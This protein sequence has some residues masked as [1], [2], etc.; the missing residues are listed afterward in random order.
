MIPDSWEDDLRRRRHSIRN[1]NGSTH[2]EAIQKSSSNEI[3][4]DLITTVMKEGNLLKQ[5]K[6][7][8]KL[9]MKIKCYN[10]FVKTWNAVKMFPYI[11]NL[12][13]KLKQ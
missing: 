1:P 4:D 12:H 13:G 10:A 8:K 3:N 9:M 6:K 11:D 7:F 5:Q 2:N